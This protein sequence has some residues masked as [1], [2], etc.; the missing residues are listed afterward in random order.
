MLMF[1]CALWMLENQKNA[2]ECAVLSLSPEELNRRRD[3]SS[4]TVLEIVD[5]LR[6]VED[7]FAN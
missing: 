5:H 4:W 2:I 3:H 1:K 7:G 6:K